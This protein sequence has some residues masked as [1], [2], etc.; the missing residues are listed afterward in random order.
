ME[1]SVKSYCLRL[2]VYTL[3]N[4]SISYFFK[5]K[6]HF[7]K[8]LMDFGYQHPILTWLDTV[9]CVKNLYSDS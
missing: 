3:I 4:M 2:T 9:Y 5:Q 8:Q 7:A 1:N 6:L